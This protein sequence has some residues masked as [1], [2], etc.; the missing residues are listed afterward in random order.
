MA[1]EGGVVDNINHEVVFA[2]DLMPFEKKVVTVV[3]T[4][5]YPSSARINNF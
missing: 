5:K 4:A 1:S 2:L 3:I